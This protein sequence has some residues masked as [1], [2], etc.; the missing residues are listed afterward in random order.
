M[1][2]VLVVSAQ[3]MIAMSLQDEYEVTAVHPGDLGP[4]VIERGY[5]VTVLDAADVD[6]TVH[7]LSDL[8]RVLTGPLL[9]LAHDQEAALALDAAKGLNDIRIGPPISGATLRDSLHGIAHVP[10]AAGVGG[11]A[12]GAREP[13]IDEPVP[14]TRVGVA[15]TLHRDNVELERRL[16]GRHAQSSTLERAGT[17]AELLLLSQGLTA[18]PPATATATAEQT[19][20]TAAR[21]RRAELADQQM[22]STDLVDALLKRLPAMLGVGVVAAAVADDACQRVRATASAVLVSDAGRCVVAAGVGLRPLEKRLQ[23]DADH[24]LVREV[25]RAGHGLIVEDT[26][27]ARRDLVGAPL[28]A[29]QHLLIVPI[30][31]VGGLLM[32]ARDANDVA[33]TSP[34]LAAVTRLASEAAGP[35]HEALRLRELGRRLTALDAE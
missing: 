29:S 32:V 27:I 34:E 21:P 22:S 31:H 8:P 14:R 7:L 2:R 4:T 10:N 15:A 23:L 9:L 13:P 30:T 26:D 18:P 5:D 25:V 35:L 3:T 6:A 28:G 17:P 12:Q 19:G 20:R 16:H 24:W 11:R 33:F 1:T